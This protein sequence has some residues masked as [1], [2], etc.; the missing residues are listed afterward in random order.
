MEYTI[1]IGVIVLI[2]MAMG[3]MIKRVTQA[4]IKVVA[5]QVGNQEA[6][7]QTFD[8]D[9]HMDNA[10]ISTRASADKIRTEISSVTNYIYADNTVTNSRQLTNLGFTEESP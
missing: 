5:D 9:G 10:Y 7:E 4:M 3:P 1:V 6:S 2:I 8:E